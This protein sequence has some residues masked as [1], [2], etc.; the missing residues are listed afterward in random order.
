MSIKRTTPL[1][2]SLS[3]DL[4]LQC[5]PKLKCQN[6]ELKLKYPS[7]PA[8]ARTISDLKKKEGSIDISHCTGLLTLSTKG[9]K[10]FHI[11]NPNLQSDKQVIRRLKASKSP[12]SLDSKI[13]EAELKSKSSGFTNE[14]YTIYKEIFSKIIEK[15]NKNKNLLIKIKNKYE[16]WIDSLLG[17]VKE[18]GKVQIDEINE[19][20][21]MEL[22]KNQKL[23]MKIKSLSKENAKIGKEKQTTREEFD[24]IFES[25]GIVDSESF[26]NLDD[27]SKSKVMFGLKQFVEQSL[28]EMKKELKYSQLF[29]KT[30]YK[31]FNLFMKKG[32]PIEAVL[33]R[34]DSINI[35]ET[36]NYYNVNLAMKPY[37]K[38][39]KFIM[40]QEKE[41]DLLTFGDEKRSPNKE[42]V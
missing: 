25:F 37:G 10:T 17:S 16:G 31:I 14:T 8:K 36:W 38:M 22:K 7:K 19:K 40:A 12:I 26:I 5:H 6:P 4:D 30:I 23:L 42:E 33:K 24:E 29:E 20:L 11:R 13:Q 1:K 2:Y 34:I 41:D 28:S 18:Q 15:T 32:Y 21:D 27:D 35:I 9:Q 39:V 3:S